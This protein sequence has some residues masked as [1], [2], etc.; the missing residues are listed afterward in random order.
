MPNI[1]RL[2]KT[3]A[4]CGQL[5][6]RESFYPRKD[7]ATENRCRPCAVQRVLERREEKRA[8]YNAYMTA[9][10]QSPAGKAAQ[11]RFE[12]SPKGRITRSRRNLK[13]RL[14]KKRIVMTLTAQ[15]WLEVLEAHQ[16]R[17]SYCGTTGVPLTMDHV[18]PISKGGPHTKDNVVPAC[19]PCNS[20]KRDR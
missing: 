17:C 7:G 3:C 9:Y 16:N 20:R 18:V 15:E 5:L 11:A 8:E 12:A 13:R 19:R 10:R 14:A 6:P 1:K 4:G 2:V